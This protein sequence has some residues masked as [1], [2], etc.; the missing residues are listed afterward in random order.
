MPNERVAVY[1]DGFNLLYGMKAVAQKRYYWLDL[2]NLA[3][4]LLRN[5]QNLARSDTSPH[6]STQTTM[7][8]KT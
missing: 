3:E 7:T 1:V 6:G 4:S 2:H 5:H 8:P